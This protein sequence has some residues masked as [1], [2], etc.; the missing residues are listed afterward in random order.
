MSV[1]DVMVGVRT[2]YRVSMMGRLAP[3]NEDH[4]AL[5]RVGIVVFEE[6]EVIGAIVSQS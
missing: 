5:T 2:C 4:I 1:N 3:R 6:E